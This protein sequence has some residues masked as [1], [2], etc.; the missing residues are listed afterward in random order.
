M[1]P[2]SSKAATVVWPTATP[3][4]NTLVGLAGRTS[5]I[6]G[7]AANRLAIG[8]EA[9]STLPEP[10]SSTSVRSLGDG[11]A[12]A[13]VTAASS[14]SPTAAAVTKRCITAS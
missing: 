8:R 1:S 10:A 6:F 2:A 14:S 9:R 5:A 12:G 13:A 11:A 7:S 4:T 3:N